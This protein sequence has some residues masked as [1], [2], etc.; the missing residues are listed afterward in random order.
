[1]ELTPGSVH[2]TTIGIAEIQEFYSEN[3]A[4]KVRIY[5]HQVQEDDGVT[6]NGSVVLM[7]LSPRVLES[8]IINF[9]RDI[10]ERKTSAA[11][12]KERNPQMREWADRVI[13][14]IDEAKTQSP[15]IQRRILTKEEARHGPARL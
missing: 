15:P 10:A 12:L 1:M 7:S 4:Q 13:Q 3:A 9:P 6:P 8:W 11:A 5:L 14:K 2:Y